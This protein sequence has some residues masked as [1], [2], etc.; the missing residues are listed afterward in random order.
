MQVCS[1]SSRTKKEVS[2]LVQ[3]CKSNYV[4]EC[5]NPII[6]Y[7]SILPGNHWECHRYLC[8]TVWYGWQ[9]VVNTASKI[10]GS[11]RPSLKDIYNSQSYSYHQ[12][13]FLPHKWIL[14]LLP[15]GRKYHDLRDHTTRLLTSFYS[16][17]CQDPERLVPPMVTMTRYT[18]LNILK[19]HWTEYV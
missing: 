12:R 4:K 18:Q 2:Q 1:N 6:H 14:K 15:S 19:L 16:P 8:V 3:G 13:H 10:I 7:V 11:T 17:G 9:H 5:T